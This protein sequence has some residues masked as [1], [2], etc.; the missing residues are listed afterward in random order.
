MKRLILSILACLLLAAP[1]LAFDGACQDGEPWKL[2]RMNP[3]VLGSGG[4]AAACVPTYGDE[5]ATTANA[6]DVGGSETDATT[7]W[8]SVGLATFDSIDTTP[9]SGTYHITAVANSATDTL[10]RSLSG[11]SASTMYKVSL[12]VRHDGT[13]AN[14]GTWRCYFSGASVGFN[15][16]IS[17]LI[18]KTDTSYV[19]YT[20]YFYYNVREDTIACQERNTDN[21]G[22]V[23]VDSYGLKAVT[24]PCL[25]SELITGAHAA[26]LVNEADATTGFTSTGTATF[27]SSSSSPADGSYS[28][29]M[30]ANADAGRFYIDISSLLTSGHK[31]F[32]SWKHKYSAGDGFLCGFSSTSALEM[33]AD[34]SESVEGTSSDTSWLHDG[35]SFVYDSDHAYF[36]CKELG[37]NNNADLYF[38]SFSIKEI[39]SE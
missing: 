27:E 11:L 15:T 5:L 29:H 38:D 35:F 24:S 28:I 30:V 14:T 33:A 18:N 13:A 2:A 16:Y 39:T 25:G 36:G 34:A 10:Y 26:S 21:D 9:Q 12:Y 32:V 17:P 19:Q 6:S 4:S 31:Y 7:G 22:G 23:Y 20:K 8:A 37:A 1:A 3:A